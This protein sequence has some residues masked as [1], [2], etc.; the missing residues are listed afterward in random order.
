M[1]VDVGN[2]LLS[3]HLGSGL[4][5]RGK[6]EDRCV[7]PFREPR[8]Q[9]D[10][11]IGELEDMLGELGYAVAAEA[12]RIDQA[13]EATKNADFDCDPRRQ[14]QRPARLA[15]CRCPCCPGLAVGLCHGLW[16]AARALSRPADAQEAVPDGWA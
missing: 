1:S 15:C 11:A 2:A 3:F 12:A 16:R 6:R 4:G 7:L 8:Q 14:S 13:L 9:H 5:L 10:V